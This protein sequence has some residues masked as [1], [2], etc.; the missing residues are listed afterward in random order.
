LVTSVP[1]TLPLSALTGKRE[2]KAK[3]REIKAKTR[4]I[5]AKTREIGVVLAR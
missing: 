4:E 5:K 2:T 3:T 1:T